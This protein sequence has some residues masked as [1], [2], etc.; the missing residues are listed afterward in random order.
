MPTK[1]P[2]SQRIAPLYHDAVDA[3]AATA[4]AAIAIATFYL[5]AA[6][7]RP[8]LA[9]LVTAQVVLAATALGGAALWLRTRVDGSLRQP[10]ARALALRA[11]AP[12]ALLGAVLVGT[13]VW[14]P[15]LVLARWLAEHLHVAPR[16][17]GLERLLA[18]PMP[19]LT[20][21]ALAVVP[22]LCEELLFR[23]LWARAL[24]P[25]V[26]RGLACVITAAAFG[27]YHLS[28]VQLAPTALLGVVLAWASLR[29]GSLWLAVALHA[30]NNA[31][32]SSV[33]AGLVGSVAR[34]VALYPSLSLALAVCV[35]ILGGLLLARPR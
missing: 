18:G 1:T 26:G 7:S 33:A 34:G 9:S 6:A 3:S 23:G 5:T 2:E 27:A 21:A 16:V 22:A 12:S 4:I 32:A 11:P 19:A 8:T 24:A 17:Q 13:S 29:G 35:S 25:R 10:L 20:I 28:V 14:L 31:V 30:T 15:N